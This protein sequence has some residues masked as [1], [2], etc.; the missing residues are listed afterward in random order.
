[1][2]QETY[3][4]A[5]VKKTHFY[6]WR[7]GFRDGHASVSDVQSCGRPSASTNDEHIESVQTDRRKSIHEISAEV[8]MSVGSIHTIFTRI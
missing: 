3:G 5:A 2:L 7:K 6:E 1:M 4:K 8:G